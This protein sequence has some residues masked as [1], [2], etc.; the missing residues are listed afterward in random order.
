MMELVIST[1]KF[2]PKVAL[3]TNRWFLKS[4]TKYCRGSKEEATRTKTYGERERDEGH[5]G[6]LRLSRSS[7]GFKEGRTFQPREQHE[8]SYKDGGIAMEGGCNLDHV[9]H[10]FPS[11][12]A[13][14]SPTQEQNLLAREELPLT[15]LPHSTTS[16]P[17]ASSAASHLRALCTFTA[18]T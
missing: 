18:T 5:S 1:P 16:N 3:R 2:I 8:Q 4:H 11:S 10:F 9:A 13:P 12:P 6:C 7:P 14:C 15:S 17:S